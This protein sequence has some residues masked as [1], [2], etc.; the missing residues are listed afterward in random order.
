[1]C[2]MV[3]EPMA[4]YGT[5]SY[6]DVMRLLHTMRITPEVKEQVGHRLVL[7]VRAKHLAKAY[8]RLEQLASLRE[9]WDGEGAKPISHKVLNNMKRTLP[10][11][12]LEHFHQTFVFRTLK[13]LC[14]LLFWYIHHSNIDLY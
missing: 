4:A 10:K 5:H 3:K 13:Q 14:L 8:S 9:D 6:A 7:E 1:M 12:V 11:M 2:M